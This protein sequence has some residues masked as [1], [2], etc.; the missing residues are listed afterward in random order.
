MAATVGG[1]LKALLEGAGLG[2]AVYRDEVPEDEPYPHVVVHEALA[3]VPEPEFNQ[4]DDPQGHV[5]E[6]VSID[7]W[8]LRRNADHSIN[9]AT[10]TLR[11][12]VARALQGAT[13]PE[14]P[15]Q[16]MGVLVQSMVRA[17]TPAGDESKLVHDVITIEVRRVLER[18]P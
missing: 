7:I 2:I 4:H 5:R 16:V 17:P 9:V 3:I 15:F 14:A 13:L 18:I 1:A 6:T 8:Q 12:A 11:D 10:Y